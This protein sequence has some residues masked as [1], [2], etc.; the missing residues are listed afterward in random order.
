MVRAIRAPYKKKENYKRLQ[1]Y[2]EVCKSWLTVK[3]TGEKRDWFQFNKHSK[4]MH[5]SV[6]TELAVDKE[7]EP[8]FIVG[9][10][11][12]KLKFITKHEKF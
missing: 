2:D 3:E 6:C 11:I 10:P 8:G 12:M 1:K 9:R 4:T 7:R 5:C